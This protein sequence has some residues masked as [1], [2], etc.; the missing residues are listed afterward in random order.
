MWQL[1]AKVTIITGL[2]ATIG[3]TCAPALAQAK[4]S[5]LLANINI[6][7]AERVSAEAGSAGGSAFAHHAP[8]VADVLAT[9]DAPAAT[10]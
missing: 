6:A 7:G 8:Y 10:D 9:I 4:A 1:T 3:E 5:V 2:G